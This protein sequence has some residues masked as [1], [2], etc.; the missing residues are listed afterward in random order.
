M[1]CTFVTPSC[2]LFINEA[3]EEDFKKLVTGIR[4]KVLT[5]FAKA[6]GDTK[7]QIDQLVVS[8]TKRV[9]EATKQLKDKMYI[10]APF[11]TRNSERAASDL[12]GK[13]QA[14]KMG[15]ITILR[16]L[17]Q[18]E[19]DYA[20]KHNIIIEGLI[21][22]AENVTHIKTRGKKRPHVDESGQNK[23]SKNSD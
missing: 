21:G 12:E 1:E 20:S 13:L 3:S 9:N 17:Q 2:P 23:R 4:F 14:H 19:Q 5:R 10:Y 18:K 6:E 16:S 22:N 7:D 8:Q 15:R 11:L